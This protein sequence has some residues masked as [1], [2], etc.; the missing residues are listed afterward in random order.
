MQRRMAI[1]LLVPPMTMEEE[2]QFADDAG[3][4][5]NDPATGKKGF[6]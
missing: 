3:D 4:Q 1:P 6:F 2:T 5:G